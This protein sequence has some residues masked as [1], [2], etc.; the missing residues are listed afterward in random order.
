MS[1]EELIKWCEKDKNPIVNYYIANNL[2]LLDM[3]MNTGDCNTCKVHNDC[4]VA[5]K[6]GERVRYN[7]AFYRSE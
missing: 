1:L 2:K 7:C 6:P 5:P 4:P 3:I